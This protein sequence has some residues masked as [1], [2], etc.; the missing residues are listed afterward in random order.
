[1]LPFYTLKTIREI[2][3]THIQLH[4]K[5]KISWNKFNQSSERQL[6]TWEKIIANETIDKGLISKIHKQP[7]QLNIRKTNNPIKKWVENLKTFFHRRHT[8]G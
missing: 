8:D 2:K 1:M 3:I 7:M 6:S 4:K 5:N